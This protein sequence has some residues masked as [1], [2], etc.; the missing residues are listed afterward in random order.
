MNEVN[1]RD[2]YLVRLEDN[3]VSE[4]MTLRFTMASFGLAERKWVQ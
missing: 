2:V 1:A 3:T 4:L